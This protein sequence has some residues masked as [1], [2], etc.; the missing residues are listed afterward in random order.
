MIRLPNSILSGRYQNLKIFNFPT[1][2]WQ[3]NR[4]T[5]SRTTKKM[6][7]FSIIFSLLGFIVKK[8]KNRKLYFFSTLPHFLGNQTQP[9]HQI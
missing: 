3:P 7:T 2:S 9:H 5:T 4:I 6:K 1:L 8:K